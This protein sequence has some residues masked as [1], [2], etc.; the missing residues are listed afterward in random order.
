MIH[1]LQ[2]VAKVL[3]GRARDSILDLIHLE[4]A[5][6]EQALITD[7]ETDQLDCVLPAERII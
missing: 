3:V 7:A 4:K 2:T 1:V 6:C 5:I